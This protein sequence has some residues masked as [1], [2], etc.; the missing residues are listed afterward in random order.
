MSCGP[1]WACPTVIGT[2]AIEDPVITFYN[3]NIPGAGYLVIRQ[4]GLESD[5][6]LKVR[7]AAQ[8]SEISPPPRVELHDHIPVTTNGQLVMQMVALESVDVRAAT[9]SQASVVEFRKGGMHLML[10]NFPENLKNS[11]KLALVLT[12]ENAGDVTVNF[13]VVK[14]ASTDMKNNCSCPNHKD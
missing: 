8:S 13:K 3:G 2:L 10:Y 11:D 7:L 1:L 4:T 12:F 6:L 9:E 5:R 14:G